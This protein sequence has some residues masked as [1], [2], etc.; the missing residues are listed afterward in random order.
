[1]FCPD[2]LPEWALW[3]PVLVGF[4]LSQL[5][6]WT[7]YALHRNGRIEL[8]RFGFRIN[9][10]PI[11]FPLSVGTSEKRL[12]RLIVLIYRLSVAIF[13]MSFVASCMISF[14]RANCVDGTE[15]AYPNRTFNIS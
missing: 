11:I 7:L 15:S 13:L 1:M 2:R 12:T 10:L 4:L 3:A 6:G 5:C 14:P 8:E 9:K